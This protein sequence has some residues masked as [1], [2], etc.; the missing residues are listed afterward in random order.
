MNY[1]NRKRVFTA[2]SRLEKSDPELQFEERFEEIIASFQLI[3]I[4]LRVFKAWSA[5]KR[6]KQGKRAKQ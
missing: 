1:N 2:W 4:G 5:L 3:T 6:S